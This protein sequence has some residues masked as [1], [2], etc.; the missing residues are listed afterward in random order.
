MRANCG[1]GPGRH[2]LALT[3]VR[4]SSIAAC[5]KIPKAAST[6]CVGITG[7]LAVA[8]GILYYQGRREDKVLVVP[9]SETSLWCEHLKQR[10]KLRE[11]GGTLRRPVL[12]AKP[13]SPFESALE[14]ACAASASLSGSNSFKSIKELDTKNMIEEEPD[15]EERSEA[16]KRTSKNGPNIDIYLQNAIF[17]EG[18]YKAFPDHAAKTKVISFDANALSSVANR[19]DHEASPGKI[20]FSEDGVGS[21]DVLEVYASQGLRSV[22]TNFAHPVRPGGHYEQGSRTQEEDLCRRA[23][24]FWQSLASQ[25][26]SAGFCDATGQEPGCHVDTSS[27]RRHAQIKLT[28]NVHVIR[29][30]KACLLQPCDWFHI[31]ILTVAAPCFHPGQLGLDMSSEEAWKESDAEAKKLA[32]QFLLSD[33]GKEAVKDADRKSV[34]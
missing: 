3:S 2:H 27:A 12:V 32:R 21:F 18:L 34:V 7:A 5:D 28:T 22:G 33:D 30:S 14:E 10:R 6:G 8:A 11:A 9:L 13:S 15:E 16:G 31:A 26:A 24:N 17:F 29:D 23:P 19:P 1:P 25:K 20:T 4:L